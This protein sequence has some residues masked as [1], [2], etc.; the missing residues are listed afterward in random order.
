MFV[1][2]FV[3]IDRAQHTVVE[4]VDEWQA[5]VGTTDFGISGPVADTV[6]AWLDLDE[7]AQTAMA[8]AMNAYLLSQVR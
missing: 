2:N 1:G 8:P 5:V 3:V 4:R 7:S 6:N